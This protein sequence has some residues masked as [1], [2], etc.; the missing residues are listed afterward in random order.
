MK[1]R[2][3]CALLLTASAIHPAA[4]AVVDKTLARPEGARHYL[5]V[6]PAGLAPEKRPTVIL[7]HGH[8]ASAAST[9]GLSTFMGYRVHDW[10]RLAEREKI[11]LL[12]PDGI[13]ASDGKQAWNDCRGDTTTNA[14]SDDVG[15][16]SE[17]I[18]KAISEHHADPERIYVYGASNGGGMAYRLGIEIAPR[19][20]AIGVSG[21][22]MAARSNCKAPSQPLSVF[23]LHGTADEISPYRGGEVGH[24][25]MRGR[26]TGLSAEES[27]AMWR[28]NG[29]LPD[30]PVIYRYPHLKTDD[31]TSATRYV[32]GADPAQVQV[33]LV[34]VDGGGHAHASKTEEFPWL[35]RKLLGNMNH[36]VNMAEEMWNFFK[37]KRAHR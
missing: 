32:W 36:D 12:A 23:M 35:L 37:E 8:G 21:A 33:A 34:R 16:L 2:S 24:W 19:L 7:L 17:L 29:A 20:A 22:L 28:K 30:A 3:I 25:L 14:P 11:L 6:E 4:A 31:T 1:A 18:D 9:V 15:F 13:K 10:L 27:A 26:G 5:V